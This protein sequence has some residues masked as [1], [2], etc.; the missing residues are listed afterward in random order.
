MGLLSKDR[1]MSGVGFSAGQA[2]ALEDNLCGVGNSTPASGGG[3]SLNP[4][5]TV[6]AFA[7]QTGVGN[8]ADTTEDTLKTFSLPANA[9]DVANRGVQITAFGKYA[10][11][12]NTKAVKVYFG[13]TAVSVGTDNNTNWWAEVYVYKTASNAQII[14]GL[15]QHGTT[16]GAPSIAN[17]SE[18]DTAAITIKV[19]GQDST[20]ATANA[21]VLNGLFI[22]FLN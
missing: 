8:G 2:Q 5:G 20:S 3:V 17:G 4:Q 18:T 19:T 1:L 21:I 15:T 7:S 16:V 22:E 14:C 11:N 13:A 9:F 10:N 6:F 12:T